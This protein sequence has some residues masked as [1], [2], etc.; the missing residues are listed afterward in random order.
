LRIYGELVKEQDITASSRIVEFTVT[1]YGPGE[2]RTR[3][4]RIL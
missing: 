3:D 4:M 2:T 1:T